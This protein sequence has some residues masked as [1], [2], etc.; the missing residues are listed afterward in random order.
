MPQ[1]MVPVAGTQSKLSWSLATRAM[2]GEKTQVMPPLVSPMQ[3][4]PFFGRKTRLELLKSDEVGSILPSHM[5]LVLAG[6]IAHSPLPS[7]VLGTLSGTLPARA[8]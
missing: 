3:E 6:G 7:E 2:V 4:S 8:A 1:T 5:V